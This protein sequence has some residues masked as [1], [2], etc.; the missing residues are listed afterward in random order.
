M[1]W[2]IISDKIFLLRK[3]VSRDRDEKLGIST[4][5]DIVGK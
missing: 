3:G 4:E 5:V 2:F 1:K